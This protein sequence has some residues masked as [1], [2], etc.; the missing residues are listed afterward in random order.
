MLM[1]PQGMLTTVLCTLYKIHHIY[2]CWTISDYWE[3]AS[4]QVAEKMLMDKLF[5]TMDF[6]DYCARDVWF[7]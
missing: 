2:V 6:F 3:I 1:L 4:G 5:N 7:V